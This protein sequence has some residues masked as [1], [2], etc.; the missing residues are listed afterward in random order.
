[1][2]PGTVKSDGNAYLLKIDNA[3]FEPSGVVLSRQLALKKL[4]GE[5]EIGSIISKLKLGC[6]MLSDKSGKFSFQK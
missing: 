4:T 1:M 6:T 5:E 3:N 2:F